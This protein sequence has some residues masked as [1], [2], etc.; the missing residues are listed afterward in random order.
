MVTAEVLLNTLKTEGK[1]F[2]QF[3][4]IICFDECHHTNLDHPYNK[5]MQLYLDIKLCQPTTPELPQ[6][7]ILSY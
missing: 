7:S 6:V 1:E 2:L 3:F 5:I 4:T